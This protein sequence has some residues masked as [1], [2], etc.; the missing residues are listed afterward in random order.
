MLAEHDGIHMVLP[1]AG[2][3]SIFTLWPPEQFCA[4]CGR[5]SRSGY[6]GN[7]YYNR[8]FFPSETL[9]CLCEGCARDVLGLEP[10]ELT[11]HRCSERCTD[12]LHLEHVTTT[13]ADEIIRD[14]TAHHPV[15]VDLEARGWHI[16]DLSCARA[17][18][19]TDTDEVALWIE[20][21]RKL[22]WQLLDDADR[23]VL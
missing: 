2:R 15:T 1:L 20:P 8:V 4:R 11:G 6:V 14:T 16:A 13:E 18:R 9:Q 17:A 7:A 19:R 12:R 3:R 23:W 22:P 10:G 21:L 5:L